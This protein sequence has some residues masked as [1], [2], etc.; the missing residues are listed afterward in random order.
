MRG[1]DG[2]PMPVDRR[3][4]SRRL[5]HRRRIRGGCRRPIGREGRGRR[6]LRLVLLLGRQVADSSCEKGRGGGDGVVPR[7]RTMEFR[8]LEI[9]LS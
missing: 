3:Q 5:L 9:F 8:R 4:R 7:G 6:R 1:G 2:P